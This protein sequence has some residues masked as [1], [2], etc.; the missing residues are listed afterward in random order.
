MRQH[1]DKNSRI[2]LLWLV[3]AFVALQ[4]I[5]KRIS[6]AIV[7][8]TDSIVLRSGR[9]SCTILKSDDPLRNFFRI[10]SPQARTLAIECA[11]LLVILSCLHSHRISVNFFSELE[12]EKLLTTCNF[13]EFDRVPL[14][15]NRR[16]YDTPPTARHRA[17]RTR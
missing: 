14:R 5:L 4:F 7:F 2:A 16:D 17:H 1:F 8:V 9:F 6:T 11:G 15:T 12:P 13:H 10:A 3:V